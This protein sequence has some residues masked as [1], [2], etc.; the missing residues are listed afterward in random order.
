[1]MVGPATNTN[2]TSTRASTMLMLDSHWMPRSTPETTEATKA[3][4]RTAMTAT[5]SAV[6]TDSIHPS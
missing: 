3:T 2:T 6:P 4:V 1:M 5:R